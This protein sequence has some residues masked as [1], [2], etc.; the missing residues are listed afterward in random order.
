MKI[1]IALILAGFA[2]SP[3]IAA[4]STAP[5]TP[6]EI[7][8]A[9]PSDHWLPIAVGDLMVLKIPD[10]G[11]G[12]S[13]EIIIQLLPESL[14]GGH[15]RNVRKLAA[16]KWWDGTKIYRVAPKFVTQFG[17]NPDG[18][19]KPKSLENVAES[20]YFNVAIGAKRNAD[21][22]ALE[23][24]RV[25]S[26]E[27]DGTD[28]PTLMTIIYENFGA[29][30]GFGGGW[31]IG[32]KDGRTYALAC[33]GTLSP[34]HYDPP[35][36]G[37]GT[38]LSVVTGEE[39]RGLDTKFGNIGRVIDGI[40]YLINLPE[41]DKATGGFY[42][43]KIDYIPIKSVRL[44]SEL[45]LDQQPNYKYLASTSPYL[46]QYIKAHGGYGNICTVPVPI[47]KSK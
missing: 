16:A 37:S 45:P 3:A 35:D 29:E 39:A 32:S 17:G 5:K 13:R 47:I 30:V 8:E 41:G 40:D 19:I 28:T 15:V 14:S 2:T 22:T 46:L 27:H 4:D 23:K 44:A 9:V 38:E 33:K 34:A 12:N 42:K 10:D 18:K 36:T 24:A 43:N 6:N 21:M 11:N 25:Y 20:E 1:I 31:P 26:N 7:L